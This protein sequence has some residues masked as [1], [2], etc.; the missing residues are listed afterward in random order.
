MP[1][2]RAE[3][4]INVREEAA[5]RDNRALKALLALKGITPATLG[6]ATLRGAAILLFAFAWCA[7][8]VE[9]N[10]IWARPETTNRLS[11]WQ[12]HFG[13]DSNASAFH[14]TLPISSNTFATNL[15]AGDWFFAITVIGTNGQ[16]S[17][18][19]P[20]TDWFIP[21]KPPQVRIVQTLTLMHS[22]DGVTW[23]PIGT[24]PNT[25][26]KS[27]FRLGGTSSASPTNRPRV[28]TKAINP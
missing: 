19:S 9:I 4:N 17:D 2:P 12:L 20:V 22:L 13:R 18:P 7:S 14:V 3:R 24:M 25:N 28:D 8:A 15:T 5:L 16:L 10:L 6:R 27:F 21:E 1:I 11:A 26:G 23:L